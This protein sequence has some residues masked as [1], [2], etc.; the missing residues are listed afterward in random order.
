HLKSAISSVPPILSG[1]TIAP[2]PSFD[3]AGRTEVHD[4][5]VPL[6][7]P[8]GVGAALA[9][10]V[11]GDS[12]FCRVSGLALES[13]RAPRRVEDVEKPFVNGPGL[14]VGRARRHALAQIGRR[15]L[16]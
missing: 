4:T 6:A 1:S 11:N 15:R 3:A 5:P 16:N 9:S 14:C 8:L 7:S 12:T 13:G 2:A 10:R